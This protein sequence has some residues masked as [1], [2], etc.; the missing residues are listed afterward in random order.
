MNYND[1][2]MK[3]LN[4]EC[5]DAEKDE[6]H[7]YDQQELSSSSADMLSSSVTVLTVFCAEEIEFFNFTLFV[8]YEEDNIVTADKTVYYCNVHLFVSQFQSIAHL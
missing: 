8:K 4:S 2:A 5:V 6:K 3:S 7:E 1:Y